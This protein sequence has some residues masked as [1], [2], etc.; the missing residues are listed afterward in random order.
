[1]TSTGPSPDPS[2]VLTPLTS[3]RFFAALHLFA[4][5]IHAIGAIRPDMGLTSFSRWPA[6]LVTVIKQ[7]WFSTPLFFLLSGFILAY[8][9]ALPNGQM[10]VGKRTF[11]IARFTRIYP[12]HATLLLIAVAM[13]VPFLAMQ[14]AALVTR[15]FQN[16]PTQNKNKKS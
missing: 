9:Y 1:M 10:S 11:F 12:L 8:L 5:H 2:A 3:I 13:A 4:F 16:S 6:W 7:G 15:A 14:P